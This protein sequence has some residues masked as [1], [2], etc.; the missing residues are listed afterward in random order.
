M[1]AASRAVEFARAIRGGEVAIFPS[2]TVYGLACDPENET[3]VERLYALKGRAPGKAAAV[4]F[5]SLDAALDAL[6][7]IGERTRAALSALT[8]GGV[9]LLL[10]NPA[11]RFPLACRADPA[12]LGVR[13]VDLPL[14]NGVQLAVLQSSANRSGGADARTLAAV[15][16]AMRAGAGLVIDGGELPGVPSTV[17]D[18][19]TY[20]ADRHWRIVR[21]GLVKSEAVAGRLGSDG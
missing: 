5:F 9:T 1:S 17:V 3:A 15:A 21:Q 4:M 14:L 16:P 12:T 7:E 11:R 8:P 2:D 19:R 18:L 20:E 10:A 6:P 13:V